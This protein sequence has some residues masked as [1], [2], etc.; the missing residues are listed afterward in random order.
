MRDWT[1]NKNSAMNG[2]WELTRIRSAILGENVNMPQAE[3]AIH[4]MLCAYAGGATTS[5][6]QLPGPEKSIL[7]RTKFT[8]YAMAMVN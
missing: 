5:I 6:H 4:E 8:F 7:K 2:W 1:E 3:A